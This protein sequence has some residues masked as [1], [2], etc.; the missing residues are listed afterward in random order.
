M[1]GP[2]K[3]RE[4]SGRHIA[5]RYS[6]ECLAFVPKE[7]EDLLKAPVNFSLARLPAGRYRWVWVGALGTKQ[8]LELLVIVEHDR[9]EKTC[10][11]VLAIP[12]SEVTAISLIDVPQRLDA[13]EPLA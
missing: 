3:K 5:K 11:A 7:V 1:P 13:A 6:I 2:N 4:P 10:K 8:H 9:N 12:A